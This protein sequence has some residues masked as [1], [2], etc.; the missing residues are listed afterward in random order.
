MEEEKKGG[1]SVPDMAGS[2]TNIVYYASVAK[3]SMIVAHNN[4]GATDLTSIAVE[5]LE[6]VPCFHSRFTYSTNR[7]IFACLIESAFTYCA[8]VDESLGNCRAFTFL[9]QV[10]NEFKL[11]LQE[12]GLKLD[13]EGLEE[14]HCLDHHFGPVLHRLI[15]PF[16]GVVPWKEENDHEQRENS[17]RHRNGDYYID[18]DTYREPSMLPGGSTSDHHNH[19]HEGVAQREEENALPHR[20][21]ERQYHLS[22]KSSPLTEKGGKTSKNKVN[23][24]VVLKEIML[25]N[26]VKAFAKAHDLDVMVESRSTQGSGHNL[27]RSS[28]TSSSR[29]RGQ[30]LARRTWWRKVKLVL[31]VDIV[32]CIILFV[33]WLV[34]CKGFHCVR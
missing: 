30:Q 9:E 1:K 19:V 10:R 23:D 22:P 34:I 25:E 27:E 31:V 20:N 2:L 15:K 5:C 6:K 28:S 17:L 4:S 21:S 33:I 12:Q 13:G 7:R 14:S 24:Q 8:I 29:H 18:H 11:L 3:G 32:F 16:V 26:G